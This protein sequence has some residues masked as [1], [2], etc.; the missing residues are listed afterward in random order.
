VALGSCITAPDGRELDALGKLLESTDL[1]TL[2]RFV[3]PGRADA[4][5]A[6]VRGMPETGAM[7][8]EL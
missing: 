5:E 6:R 7:V 3:D 4:L 1:L 2:R 8:R